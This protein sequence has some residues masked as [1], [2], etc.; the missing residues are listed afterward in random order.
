MKHI[1]KN[2]YKIEFSKVIHG[3]I[4]IEANDREEAKSLALEL[5]NNDKIQW[6]EPRIYIDEV[7]LLSKNKE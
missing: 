1:E 6:S 7:Y 5:A 4:H 2:Y 3:E